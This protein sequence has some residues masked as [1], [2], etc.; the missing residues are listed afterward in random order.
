MFSMVSTLERLAKNFPFDK[1]IIEEDGTIETWATHIDRVSRLS[2]GLI[3]NDIKNGEIFGILGFNSADQARLIHAGY[4]SGQIPMPINF[5]LSLAEII[6]I[7]DKTEAK[8]LFVSD[9]FSDVALKLKT[10]GWSGRVFGLGDSKTGLKSTNQMVKDSEKESPI[11]SSEENK[12]ILLFTGGTTGEGK[13]ILLSHKNI[14]SNGFQVAAALTVS[15]SDTFLHVAP[16]F[17]SADLLGTAVTLVGGSHCYMSQPSPLNLINKIAKKKVTM[18]M[19]PPVL[20]KGIVESERNAENDFTNLRIFICGGSPV[21]LELLLKGEKL[22]PKTSMI[23]GYGLT[24]TSPILSFLNIP[25]VRK[26]GSLEAL[27]SSGK[28]LPGIEMR[29]N[30][31]SEIGELEVRGPNVFNGYFKNKSETNNH[32]NKDWFKT[33][34]IGRF[35]SR[36]YVHILD[37]QKD[38]I[39]TGGENVYSLQVEGIIL[40][41][42]KVAEVAILG[43][44]DKK[45]GEKV[46]A[47]V[48]PKK[49]QTITSQELSNFCKTKIGKYKIPKDYY[50]LESLPKTPLGKTLKANLKENLLNY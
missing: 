43:L 41:H 10:G 45:W 47:A 8:T 7:L 28:P 26:E 20:L 2:R 19:T 42:P 22:F 15:R 18:V 17:H 46:V 31:G 37:R 50:F 16:M 21:P 30:E 3:N 11:I 14:I 48:V 9:D 25:E 23:Q 32:F 4:W 6:N 36:G 27:Q 12:A 24:E 40:E 49:D 13:G 44:P 29:T 1:A 33:G 39:I 35:D 34:D 38:M 5:R